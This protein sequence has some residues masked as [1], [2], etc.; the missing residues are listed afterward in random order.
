MPPSRRLADLEKALELRYE[1]L[2]EAEKRIA[3]TDEIFS[4]NAIK[5]RIREEVFQNFASR[6]LN[7]FSGD[8]NSC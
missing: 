7:D 4:K 2:G 8:T 3:F 5:Q 6:Y 1:T